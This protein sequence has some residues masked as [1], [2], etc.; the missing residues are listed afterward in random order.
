MSIFSVDDLDAVAAC[1][2]EA[3]G[4]GLDGDWD[5]PAGTLEWS[6]RKTAD[7][8]IDTL[9]APAFFLAS[10]RTESYP[11]GGWHPG[12][13]AD[14][15]QFVDAVDMGA[16][17]LGGVVEAAPPDVRAIIFQRPVTVAPPADFAPRGALELILHAHDVCEG[18][19]IDF[20]P[21]REACE[22]LRHHVRS[23]PFWNPDYWPPLTMTGDPW[24]DLLRSSHRLP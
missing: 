6:C 5:A 12:E 14:P 4:R 16:R 19:G 17:I 1:V 24:L 11:P 2:T 21:P 9:I 3:W 7:H 8:A 23:W 20:D 10:R 13:D 15:Q 18:L 22:N